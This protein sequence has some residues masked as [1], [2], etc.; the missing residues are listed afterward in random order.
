[1]KVF[2]R[3]MVLPV[4][5]ALSLLAIAIPASAGPAQVVLNAGGCGGLGDSFLTAPAGFGRTTGCA[6]SARYLSASLS[7]SGGGFDSIAG[8]WYSADVAWGNSGLGAPGSVTAVAST[9][10]LGYF[11]S[12]HGWEG[13]NT[14]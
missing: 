11:N 3:K 8:N 7:F 1:M 5:A 6:G 12:T 9:H 14:W 4:V 13:T 10:N 2:M